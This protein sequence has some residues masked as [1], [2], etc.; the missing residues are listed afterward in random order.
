L[1]QERLTLTITTVLCF[2]A[3]KS[4]TLTIT[5]SSSPPQ[6]RGRVCHLS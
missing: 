6:T 2:V 1:L 5:V 3:G 4:F